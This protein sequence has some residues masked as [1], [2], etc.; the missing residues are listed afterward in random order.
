MGRAAWI[1]RELRTGPF[2]LS[3]AR[4]AGISHRCLSGKSWRRLASELYCW[5]EWKED[6]WP[7]IR[8]WHR[9]LPPDF[10]FGGATAAW[11]WGIDMSPINP[12]H[13]VVP[14]DSG[15][16]TRR[17]LDVRRCGLT[18]G[19]VTETRGEPATTL[20][21]TLRDLCIR[22]SAR[23]VLPAVDAAIRLKL[24]DVAA[25]IGYVAECCGA[26]GSAR[27]RAVAMVSAPAESP[28]E[29]RL[30]W[31]LMQARLPRPEVQVDLRDADGR[32]LARA[33]LYY[34]SAR[35][36]VEYDGANHRERLVEDNRRQNSLINAGFTVLRFAAADLERPEAVVSQVRRALDQ[37][38]V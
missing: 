31:V 28:M 23:D 17:G 11:L 19:E 34:R 4:A 36:V 22:L 13:V 26:P 7:V 14:T 8:A 30:R 15:L 16:R 3:E 18:C 1:P 35:L 24:T 32:F 2:T 33:D 10:V 37:T 27:L 21:R 20:H 25:L 6:P 12:I 29:S 38:Y 9:L 5:V